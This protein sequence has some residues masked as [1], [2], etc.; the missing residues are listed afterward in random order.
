MNKIHW[1]L[2]LI[3]LLGLAFLYFPLIVLVVYS[4]NDSML[5]GV[6]T[7]AST[8]WYGV[9]AH[10]TNLLQA[11]WLSIRLA[12]S[13]STLGIILGTMT[14]VALKRYGKFRGRNLLYGM[15]LTPI[16]MPDVVIGLALLLMF[17]SLGH[18]IG[19]PRHYGFGTILVA[20]TTFCTAY[21][22]I[23]IQARLTQVDEDLE[24]AALDLGAKPSTTFF[25]ITLP[26][27]IPALV[28]AWLLSFT[29]SLDDVVIT[30]FVAGP[31]STTLPMYIFATVK[32]GVTPEINALATVLIAVVTVA[33]MIATWVSF[34]AKRLQSK[35]RSQS[36][37]S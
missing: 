17:V 31:S 11:A 24:E 14:A 5:V 37:L 3:L 21:A 18:L 15:S 22:T 35:L 34:R 10:D 23:V 13:A 20:H 1:S 27:I 19:F 36:K 30:S 29:L 4:F 28:S 25:Q 6:W 26:Q 2:K 9:M 7:H 16:V 8:R 33:L 32:S 12:I